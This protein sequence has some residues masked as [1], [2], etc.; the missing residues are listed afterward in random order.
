LNHNSRSF[1]FEVVIVAKVVSCGPYFFSVHEIVERGRGLWLE[2]KHITGLAGVRPL[3]CR[4]L[5]SDIGACFLD[6]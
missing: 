1:N 3:D 5:A 2:V 6:L 4:L